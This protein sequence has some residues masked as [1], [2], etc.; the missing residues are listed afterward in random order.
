MRPN[1]KEL[2]SPSWQR[3]DTRRGPERQ[4]W[5]WRSFCIQ[6]R[7]SSSSERRSR[8][9]LLCGWEN[10]DPGLLF[11]TR[12]RAADPD[13]TLMRCWCWLRCRLSANVSSC[14]SVCNGWSCSKEFEAVGDWRWSRPSKARNW[15]QS[16]HTFL[17]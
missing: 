5:G 16:N 12:A 7:T 17:K 3:C 1:H 4:C 6:R 13:W 11:Q 2:I 10:K 15:D 9:L 8:G 14:G